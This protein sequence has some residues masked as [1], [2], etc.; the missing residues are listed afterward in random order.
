MLLFKLGKEKVKKTPDYSIL[1]KGSKEDL[2]TIIS[3]HR[4][5]NEKLKK[6]KSEKKD[7]LLQNYHHVLTLNSNFWTIDYKPIKHIN[8]YI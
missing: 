6:E 1:K 4:D 5:E 7:K 3:I 2:I 8:I